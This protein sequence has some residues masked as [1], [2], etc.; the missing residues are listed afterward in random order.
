MARFF[1]SRNDFDPES[2]KIALSGADARHIALSLRMTPGERLTVCDMQRTE[3][4]CEITDASPECV[5]LRILT[6]RQ[7]DT[8]LP[9]RAHLYQSL[10]KGD[11][12]D[13]IV[14]KAVEL[15]VSSVTPVASA[16]CIVRLDEKK[17][18]DKRAR[19]Q[20]IAEEAAKQCGRGIIP[21]VRAPM[22][23][24]AAVEEAKAMQYALF[25][26]EGD[27]T[28]S[29]KQ[30]LEPVAASLPAC[31]ERPEI[32]FFIGPEGGYDT[33]EVACA[34]GAGIPAANLGK[35]ILRCETA[36]GF[37]LSAMICSF[38]L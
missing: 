14:Q 2:G 32:A 37:V 15:G 25:C 10:P 22:T 33:A 3:Y 1:I 34:A 21:A 27:G 8:E 18:E 24:R 19:W 38:E 26:Y 29:L 28:V 13:Y 31:T 7:N 4:L 35:R 30:L 12:M 9:V 23:F 16:R 36:S 6:V 17:A 5:D 20:K 11:K